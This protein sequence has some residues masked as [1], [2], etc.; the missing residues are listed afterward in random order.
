MAH[1]INKEIKRF[2]LVFVALMALTFLTLKASDLNIG[3]AA[4]VVVAL[5]IATAKASLVA[6]FFMHLIAEKKIIYVILIFTGIFFVGMLL[7][8][9]AAKYDLPEG[10]V[11]FKQEFR[12]SNHGTGN[13]L[14]ETEANHDKIVEDHHGS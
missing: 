12:N 10:T 7:L 5:I 11:Y 3:V 9:V 13:H 14:E 6:S 1:D 2:Y 8:T 4:A